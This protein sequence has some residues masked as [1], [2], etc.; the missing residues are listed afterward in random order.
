MFLAQT[1][2]PATSNL[3]TKISLLPALLV[4]LAVPAPGSKSTTPAKLPV[5]YALPE[6]ST[7]IPVA[8]SADVPPMLLAQIKLPPASNL[9]TK[10]SLLP[11]LVKL[12]VPAPGSKSTV[13]LK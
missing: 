1:K 10:I 13:A 7:N 8:I 6:A 9:L 5:V 4:K 11:A 2:L 12:V 3:L